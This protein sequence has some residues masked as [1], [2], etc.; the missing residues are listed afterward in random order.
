MD[1]TSISLVETSFDPS[2]YTKKGARL[3]I[4]EI[5]PFKYL[6]SKDTK[7]P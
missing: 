4:S 6:N 1:G 5:E 3:T 2:V 7:D